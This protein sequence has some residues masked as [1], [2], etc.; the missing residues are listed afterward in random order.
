MEHEMS[1]RTLITDDHDNSEI[2]IA[3]AEMTRSRIILDR[4]G[5][6][7]SLRWE[8]INLTDENFDLLI[9]MIREFCP[10]A[11]PTSPE[12]DSIT[13][14]AG[15]QAALA[16]QAATPAAPKPVAAST[17]APAGKRDGKAIRAWWYALD[18]AS[19]KALSLPTPDR[20]KNIGKLPAAVY[21]AYET[22][23]A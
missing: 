2:E 9:K 10:N 7:H 22:S 13:P 17:A 1:R 20:S 5:Q 21:T 23:Q 16:D 11:Q 18:A 8:D 15:D 14:A 3:S 19:L 4:T 6:E 12:L